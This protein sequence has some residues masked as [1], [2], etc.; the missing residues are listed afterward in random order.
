[1]NL[2]IAYKKT[3]YPS[4]AVNAAS[5]FFL[6]ANPS[7]IPTQK[8]TPRLVKT[9]NKEA[10]KI[11]PNPIVIGLS[12]KLNLSIKRGLVKTFPIAIKIPA[13]GKIRTGTNIAFEN[14]CMISMTFAFIFLA[15]SSLMYSV[16]G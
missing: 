14:F 16:Y 10:D 13:I 5:A 3:R 1:M 9:G 2:F 12:K 6:F 15:P 8:M 4:K 7:V 11:L